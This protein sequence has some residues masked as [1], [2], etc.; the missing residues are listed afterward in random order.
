[1]TTIL[2]PARPGSRDVDSA[3]ESERN[4]AAAAGFSIAL[5]DEGEL[6]FGGDARFVGL[7]REPGSVIYRGWLMRANDYER[8]AVALQE[9]GFSLETTLSDYL[10]T[11]HLPNWYSL[12][13]DTGLTPKSIWFPGNEFDLSTIAARVHEVFGRSPLVLKDYVKSR[14]HEW[15]E[16]CFIPDASDLDAIQRVTQRFLELQDDF[17]VGGL[18]YREF[19]PT[20]SV[21]LHPKSRAPMANEHRLYVWRGNVFYSR[22]YWSVAEY[23]DTRPPIELVQPIL[24]KSISPFYAVDI[25]ELERG[26]WFVVECNDGGSA[27]LPDPDDCDGFYQA[28]A[29]VLATNESVKS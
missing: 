22:P 7:P 27:G 2:F 11:Y 23:G 25:A 9:R 8:C 5:V 4:A 28:L 26:G 3:F 15:Y 20:R 18:V 24:E 29:H 10:S 13:A 17:L 14:K 1:M 6:A 16:A 21:G 19:W 12:V